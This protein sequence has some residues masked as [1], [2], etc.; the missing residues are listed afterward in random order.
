LEL[1][2]SELMKRQRERDSTGI[3]RQ[4]NI[5]ES[6]PSKQKTTKR[7]K[8]QVILR[9]QQESNAT[10]HDESKETKSED[11]GKKDPINLQRYILIQ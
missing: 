1:E 6:I 11:K 5:E 3:T 2:N 10:I 8:T 7:M 4:A 9:N